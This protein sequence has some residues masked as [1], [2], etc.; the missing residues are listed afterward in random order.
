MCHHI[1]RSGQPSEGADNSNPCWRLY[2]LHPRPLHPTVMPT[3]NKPKRPWNNPPSKSNQNDKETD[4]FYLSTYWRKLT[5]HHR[6][7]H[8]CCQYCDAKGLVTACTLTDHYLPRRLFP[9]LEHT[10]SNFRSSCDPCHNRKRRLE[11]GQSRGTILNK[12]QSNGY[13]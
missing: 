7:A 5:K 10:E 1:R 4:R 3:L 13:R 2:Y 12:L 8:P 9:E 11:A 6:R